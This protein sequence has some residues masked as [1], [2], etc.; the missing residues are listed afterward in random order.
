MTLK[1]KVFIVILILG[2]L[3]QFYRPHKNVQKE[4]SANDFLVYEKA[5]NNVKQLFINACYDCH[6][7]QTNYEWFDNIAPISWYIDNNI[8]EGVFVLNFS[9]WANYET[10]DKE[11]IFS[12]IPFNIN[13]DRM[14]TPQYKILHPK[15]ELSN[16]NKRNMLLWLEQ[17]KKRFLKEESE[18]SHY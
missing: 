9:E 16:N 18:K 7:N 8:K 3:I 1:F 5:P 17:V 10:I 13:T 4:V 11:I 12:A 2:I 15:A 14:P 6:S